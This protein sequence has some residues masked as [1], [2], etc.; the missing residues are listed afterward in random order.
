MCP[1]FSWQCKNEKYCGD[2]LLQKGYRPTFK[3]KL[4]VKNENAL[5]QYYVENNHEPIVTRELF[6]KANK[7]R[8]E[9]SDKYIKHNAKSY[10]NKT[11]YAEF[12]YCPYCGKNFQHRTNHRGTEYS[13]HMMQCKTNKYKTE[14]ESDR[15][16]L[17]VFNNQ[18][19]QMINTIIANKK[20]VL[21]RYKSYLQKQPERNKIIKKKVKL[22]E[23]LKPL[24]K[25]F[26]TL[27][28][29]DEFDMIIYNN[30]KAKITPIRNKITWIDNQLLTEFN[31][32]AQYNFLNNILNNYSNEI[33]NIEDF[34]FRDVFSKV[35]VQSKEDIKFIIGNR[36]DYVN[37]NRK[38]RM[39]N[40]V[41]FYKV[42]K[43]TYETN[44]GLYFF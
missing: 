43:R 15:I 1:T 27:N 13:L 2:A 10:A 4:K 16:S 44:S 17:Q 24:L 8:L 22:Q 11:Q 23:K 28:S 31:I 19:L 7:L 3:S 42:R 14:C 38:Q 41:S 33:N 32:D 21:R 6:H 34:P 30:L 35:I 37:F 9:R 29:K 12:L 39:Y 5:P 18:L 25:H 20:D 36:T 26:E 40:L